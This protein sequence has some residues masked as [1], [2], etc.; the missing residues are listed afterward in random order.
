MPKA[1]RGLQRPI[2][3]GIASAATRLAAKA[4]RRRAAISGRFAFFQRASG[5]I[6][7]RKSAGAISGTNTVSKYG[8][9]TEILPRPDASSASGY[10]VPSNTEPAAPANIT[11]FPSSIDSRESRPNPPPQPIPGRRPPPRGQKPPP[12]HPNTPQNKPPP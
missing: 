6:P 3:N 1:T 7:M 5:P 11:L 4:Q 12:P 10:K 9:P 2:A 8:G